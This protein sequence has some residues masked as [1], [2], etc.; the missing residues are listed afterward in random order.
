MFK[1]ELGKEVKDKVTGVTGII[2]SRAQ[3]LTGCNRYGVQRKPKKGEAP[4]EWL[5]FDENQIEVIGNGVT[6]EQTPAQRKKGGP[7]PA[8]KKY[9]N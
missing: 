4:P 3:Y 8:I 2:V 9:S 5:H 1:H 7:M 6:I